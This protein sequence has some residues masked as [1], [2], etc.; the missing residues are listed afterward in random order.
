M[1]ITPVFD[2]LEFQPLSEVEVELLES[3]LNRC[4]EAVSIEELDGLLCSVAVLP[5]DV[6]A[7]EWLKVAM[8]DELP[9]WN[10]PDEPKHM[11][12][13]LQRHWNTVRAGFRED[14]SSVQDAEGPDRLYF[15][16]LDTPEHS[17]HPLAEGWARGFRDGLEWLTDEHIDA[18]EQDEEC[19]HLMSIISAYDSGEKRPG[20]PFE[21][22]DREAQLPGMVANLQYMFGFWQRYRRVVEADRT[23]IRIDAKPGRNDPCFCGSGK[24]YKKCCGNETLH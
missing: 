11:I 8:G 6:P 21:G 5:V 16:L 20:V 22:D 1:S 9:T 10:S 24:K 7:S 17:G 12:A 4:E 13:L 18:L 15:P 23:P 14:W 19:M 3:M 2:P